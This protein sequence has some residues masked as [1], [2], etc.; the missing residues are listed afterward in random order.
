MPTF[1]PNDAVEFATH[2]ST[3]RS[4]VS[5]DRGSAQLCAWQLNVPPGTTG[6][7]HRPSREEILLVLDG[8][9]RV[10]IDD[11]VCD[12]GPGSVVLVPASSRFRVDS[13][14]SGAKA[15]VTTTV[16]LQATTDEGVVMAPSWAQ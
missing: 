8:S 16:G 9:L 5:S 13:G 10:S 12:A 1:G 3:F 14:R 2:G 11:D 6:V 4:F 7:A 15:W